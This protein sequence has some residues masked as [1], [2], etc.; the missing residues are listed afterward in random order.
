[1]WRSVVRLIEPEGKDATNLRNVSNNSPSDIESHPW[2]AESAAT[3]LAPTSLMYSN[4]LCRSECISEPSDVNNSWYASQFQVCVLLLTQKLQSNAKA[5]PHMLILTQWAAPFESH[6]IRNRQEWSRAIA[7]ATERSVLFCAL[8]CAATVQKLLHVADKNE[9][10]HSPYS[11][12]RFQLY[13]AKSALGFL[14]YTHLILYVLKIACVSATTTKFCWN[15]NRKSPTGFFLHLFSPSQ[16]F[17]G[18]TSPISV[19]FQI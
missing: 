8:N 14:F 1:M 7:E 10:A 6:T 16:I 9:R 18:N 13:R 12:S 3:Q 11:L 19:V 5:R 2:R 17:H 4:A 15:E